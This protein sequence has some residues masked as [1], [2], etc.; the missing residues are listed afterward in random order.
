MASQKL[1]S[2]R[3]ELDK[4]KHPWLT[5]DMINSKLRRLEKSTEVANHFCT[6]L[7]NV[8]NEKSSITNIGRPK[9]TSVQQTKIIEEKIIDA[10]NRI[11]VLCYEK[12]KKSV[13]KRME[14]NSYKQIH[15]SVMKAI[16]LDTILPSF[17]I[18]WKTINSRLMRNRLII[19]GPNVNKKS[20]MEKIEPII[21]QFVLWKEEAHQ[22]ITPTEGLAFANSLIMGKPIQEEIKQYQTMLKKPATGILSKRYWSLFM[23]CYKDV[24]ESKR[25]GQIANNRVKWVTYE[26]VKMM[27]DLVYKQMV[28]AG[29]AVALPENEWYWVDY[30]GFT[31]ESEAES[32]GLKVK[33]KLTDPDWLLF[34]NE[35]G[36]ELNQKDDGNVGGRKCIGKKI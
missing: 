18:P 32:T 3:I 4:T 17:S 7:V 13:S 6:D 11:S 34:G 1:A 25:G 24:I 8:E 9:G 31:V 16:G 29:I 14:C 30:N 26:N 5:R 20:P 15:D 28:Q 33:V 21:L 10:K 12:R 2:E 35:V 23:N 19:N 36:N 22:P 27:Y